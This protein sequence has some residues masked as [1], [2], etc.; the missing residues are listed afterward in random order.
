MID[1]PFTMMARND[2]PAYVETI[3]SW[4]LTERGRGWVRFIQRRIVR[5][6][7]TKCASVNPS[8]GHSFNTFSILLRRYEWLEPRSDVSFVP[9]D[10]MQTMPFSLLPNANSV[11]DSLLGSIKVYV[12]N[13]YYPFICFLSAFISLNTICSLMS[14][15][16]T[17]ISTVAV[18]PTL[19]C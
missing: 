5:F 15:L 7:I 6:D 4:R 8:E 17:E 2:V 12:I 1:F 9:N 3:E 11:L 10:V 19:N 14:C 18:V 16:T 13:D